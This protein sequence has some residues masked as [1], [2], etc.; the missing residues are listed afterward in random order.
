[1]AGTKLVSLGVREGVWE[2]RLT[3]PGETPPEV[4][5]THLGAALPEVSVRSEAA[6]VWILRV[7]VPPE[8]LGD[9]VQTYLVT[10][11]ATGTRLGSF[12]IAVGEAL[13]GDLA[14]ELELIRAELDMLKKAFRRLSARLD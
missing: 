7:P 2:G 8:S 11:V 10:D 4:E 14:A 3:A 1:M 12:A 6:G 9:G 5:V 13:D